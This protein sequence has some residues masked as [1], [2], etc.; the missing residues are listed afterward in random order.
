MNKISVVERLVD[1]ILVQD[2]ERA[3]EL[4]A[5]DVE[6]SVLPPEPAA[7]PPETQRGKQALG[8]YFRALGGIVT[9]WQVRV[10]ADGDQVLV[11][12]KESYVTT[13]GL[14][15]DTEFMLDCQVEEGLVN[16][17]LVVENVAI[18]LDETPEHIEAALRLR[19]TVF[20]DVH[21]PEEALVFASISSWDECNL[22]EVRTGY[23]G[24]SDAWS[25]SP[26]PTGTSRP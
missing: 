14:E 19:P 10:V 17:L 8:D 24:D 25:S 21:P 9:F 5:E 22:P 2:L 13:T 15:S 11:L 6:L 26:A 23:G 20:R 7:G 4:V 18:S 12:G 16:R 3:M 1:R